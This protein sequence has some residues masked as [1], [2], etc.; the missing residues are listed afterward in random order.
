MATYSTNLAI[1]LPADGEYSG[2]WGQITN[3]NLGTLLEQAVSGYV[4]QAVATGTDTTITIPNG[5]TGVARNMYLVLTGTGGASTNLIVPTNTKLYFI[6]NSTAGQVTVKVAGQTG[7]SVPAASKMILVSNGT[8]IV[9]AVTY[10][11]SLIAGAISSA[12]T[13]TAPR[14][15]VT[16]STAP[17]TGIYAAASTGLGFATGGISR[18][19]INV[20]GAWTISAPTSGNHVVNLLAG[21]NGIAFTAG[22]HTVNLY[23]DGSTN[24]NFGTA[25]TIPLRILANNVVVATFASGGGFTIAAPT[26][27]T[28]PALVAAG[29]A[30]T[31]SVSVAFSATAM[32][33]NC[34]LS[35]VFATTFTANV[36]VAPTISNPSDGQTINWFITQDA[37]GSR[38]MTWPTSFKWPGGTAGVLSTTANAVDLVVATYRSATGFWYATISKA[39]S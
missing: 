15:Y 22:S 11:S 39:F 16:S 31:T 9:D 35:N 13:V 27:T 29:G 17:T 7:V 12:G 37:T 10:F 4:S 6:Y 32:T 18:G 24:Y 33:V 8:D 5:A 25:T 30:A 1:T 36:T 38:T 14:F 28:I 34:A 26:T 19:S 3:T 23:S 2:T 20:S 21:S